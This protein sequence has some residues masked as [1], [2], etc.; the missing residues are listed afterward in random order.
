MQTSL[1]VQKV[2]ST[3]KMDFERALLYPW[4]KY[5]VVIDVVNG[6]FDFVN[7]VNSQY[8]HMGIALVYFEHH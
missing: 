2:H 1:L 8:H 5:N 7:D 6:D 3:R 4:F